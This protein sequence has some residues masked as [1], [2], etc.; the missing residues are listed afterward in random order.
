MT[1][2]PIEADHATRAIGWL[3]AELHRRQ[4]D[5]E[6]RGDRY[7]LPDPP[8]WL[9]LWHA[10]LEATADP[11]PSEA[12]TELEPEQ[13]PDYRCQ[14][15][16]GDIYGN[17]RF[18]PGCGYTVY[19]RHPDRSTEAIAERRAAAGK[20]PDPSGT[21]CIAGMIGK[22]CELPAGHD[23]PHQAEGATFDAF[24]DNR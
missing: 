16:G 12:Q 11:H 5:A 2:T 6:T 21:R 17:P 13:P 10:A 15:C 20:P 9:A 18:C 23:G 3:G 14:R 19:D 4:T 24:L 1:D 8:E 7:P 22:R